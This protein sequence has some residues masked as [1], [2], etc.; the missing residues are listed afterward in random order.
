M[1]I[2][3][4]PPRRRQDRKM[5]QRASSSRAAAPLNSLVTNLARGCATLL[6]LVAAAGIVGVPAARAD[7][8]AKLDVVEE[9]AGALGFADSHAAGFWEALTKVRTDERE[10]LEKQADADRAEQAKQFVEDASKY[11]R[12][13][14]TTIGNFTIFT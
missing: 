5:S 13:L 14:E 3:Q 10:A 1:T 7:E 2:P 8:T 4:L 6:A 9:M 12:R 11:G